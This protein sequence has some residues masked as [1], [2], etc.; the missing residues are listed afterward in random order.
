LFWKYN[1]ITVCMLT[2]FAGV[3]QVI[4]L[5]Y[6]L[7]F[8]GMYKLTLRYCNAQESKFWWFASILCLL[9]PNW[10]VHIH[11]CSEISLN[12]DNLCEKSEKIT[13]DSTCVEHNAPQCDNAP[14]WPHFSIFDQSAHLFTFWR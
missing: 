6:A 9:T 7:F 3:F 8:H 14:H 13:A 4:I 12:F 11:T 1:V 5:F 10:W 2:I